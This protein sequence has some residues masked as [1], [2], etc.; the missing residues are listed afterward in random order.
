MLDQRPYL[1]NK[2]L[3]LA[4]TPAACRDC[5]A[6]L[7]AAAWSLAETPDRPMWQGNLVVGWMVPA[8]PAHLLQ[9]R[10]GGWGRVWLGAPLR[11]LRW[12]HWLLLWRTFESVWAERTRKM[13]EHKRQIPFHPF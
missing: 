12:K 8:C 9:V 3:S 13:W 4:G 7:E 1:Q 5:N 10:V 2:L 11:E 6:P